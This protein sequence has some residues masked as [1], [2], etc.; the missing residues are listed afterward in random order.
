[1]DNVASTRWNDIAFQ[2]C[3]SLGLKNCVVR[4]AHPSLMLRSLT[5]VLHFRFG[6]DIKQQFM[7]SVQ[8]TLKVNSGTDL[9]FTISMVN[10]FEKCL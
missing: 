1:M 5:M 2:D 9:F 7:N 6:L 4:S 10:Y 8:S 3:M